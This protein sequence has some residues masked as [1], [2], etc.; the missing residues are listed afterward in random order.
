VHGG[1][2]D[3]F[4]PLTSSISLVLDIMLFWAPNAHYN[5]LRR[6]W[7]DECINAPRWKDF[8][9]NLMAEWTGIT[10]YVCVIVVN[11]SFQNLMPVCS[12]PVYRDVGRRCEF[13]CG[14]KCEHQQFAVGRSYCYIHLSYLHHRVLNRLTPAGS[15]DPEIWS[16]ISGG[17][18]KSF[19]LV[20][21]CDANSSYQAELLENMVGGFFGMEALATVHSLPYAMLM[22]G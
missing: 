14:T 13:P 8:S 12:L 20:H 5:D 3:I 11:I 10:I 17:S 18:G 6:V 1:D 21:L 22:W 7:V 16:R 9:R 2:T 4:H 19:S 15:S